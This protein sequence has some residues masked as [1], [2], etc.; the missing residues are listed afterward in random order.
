MKLT[1]TITGQDSGLPV[2]IAHGLF[3]Q[4]RNMGA[5][6]RRLGATR[7]VAVPDMR[8]HG[9]SPQHDDHGYAALAGDLAGLIGELGGKADLVGHS[10]GGKAA[11]AC[12]LTRPD[13]IRKLVIMDI[14]PVAYGHSQ[15]H[16]IDAMESLDLAQIARRSEADAAL[17]RTVE[18]PG[19]RA[20]L[21]QSLDLKAQPPRWRLNLPVLRRSMETITG[22]P[23]DL[24]GGRFEGPVMALLG[25]ESDYVD[26]AGQRALRAL[27]PQVRVVTLKQAGHWLHADAPE[28]VADTLAA[29]LGAG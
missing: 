28:A 2:I 5:L 4:G 9:D 16:L 29:F 14:A 18:S 3:G 26:A 22:W 17:A 10:M 11:M 23:G 13:L 15:T 12:A 19:L 7:R 27:F 1:H 25:A 8:N 20:F 21:L 24:P 6:A